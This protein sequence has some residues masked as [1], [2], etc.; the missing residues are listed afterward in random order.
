MTDIRIFLGKWTERDLDRI[1]SESSRIHDIGKRIDFLSRQFLDLPY[2]ETNLIGDSHTPE[3][4]VI[5][6]EGVDCLTF[7]EYLESMRLSRTF[8]DFKENLKKVR[9][10]SGD[11]AFENRNH[12][13][14][15]WVEFNANVID[16]VTKEIGSEKAIRVQK[17]L[18]EKED[19]TFFVPGIKPVMREMRYLPSE[20]INETVLNRLSMGDYI[21]IYSHLVGLD[22]SHVG[23]FIKDGEKFLLRHASSLSK[24]RK[25]I[26]EDFMEY[27]TGKP[28][29]I[30]LRPK[31][32]REA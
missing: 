7:L 11:V 13:F 9:Y 4:F 8:E 29:I 3:V 10:R 18:N 30:V 21:G 23:I 24:N 5:D 22:V 15:D 6:F 28:G 20:N 32:L 19:K 1:L 25:V 12:F 14:A 26:D 2:A 17:L 31:K 16:D 27:I